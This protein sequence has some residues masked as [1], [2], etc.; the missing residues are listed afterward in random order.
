MIVTN[1]LYHNPGF[2]AARALAAESG[3]AKMQVGAAI[4]GRD[5]ALLGAGNNDVELPQ[6]VCPREL[7]GSAS[8][9]DYELCW[10]GCFQGA[11]AEINAVN[12]A[13]TCFPAKSLLDATVYVWGHTYCCPDC[14]AYM[15]RRGITS[16]VFPIDEIGRNPSV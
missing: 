12:H 3:C 16:V 2:L 10:R 7:K 5:G 9:A 15:E 1:A 14:I 4:I 13:L 11:H 8:G 6:A